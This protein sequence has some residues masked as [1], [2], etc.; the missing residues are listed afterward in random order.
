MGELGAEA[1]AGHRRVGDAAARLGIDHLVCVGA[2]ARWIA[3]GAKARGYAHLT[4]VDDISDAARCLRELAHAGDLTLVKGSRS[5]A[6][7]TLFDQLAVT[8]KT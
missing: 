1:P 4:M 8:A 5:A 6:M 7:E 3:E 2:E